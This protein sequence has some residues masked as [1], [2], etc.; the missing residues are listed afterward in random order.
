MEPLLDGEE[1]VQKKDPMKAVEL[2]DIALRNNPDTRKTWADARAAAFGLEIA[3]AP[4]YPVL[5]YNQTLDLTATLQNSSTGNDSVTDIATMN[6]GASVSQTDITSGPNGQFDQLAIGTLSM[7]YLLLDFGGRMSAIESARQALYAANWL[8]NQRIQ[9]VIHDVLTTLNDHLAAKALLVSAQTS[10]KEAQ[11]NLDLA[12][13]Q[14]D[15]GVKTIVDVLQAKSNLVNVQLNVEQISGDVKT[16]LGQLAKAIGLPANTEFRT[17]DLPDE[18][19]LD[20]LTQS[21]QELVDKAKID[22]PD[23][24]SAE[25]FYLQKEADLWTAWS[26]GMPTLS[27]DAE[28]QKNKTIHSSTLNTTFLN[29]A[30]M[31]N[32]PIFSGFLYV[33]QVRQARENIESAYA[34]M[35]SREAQILLDVVTAYYSYKTAL[36]TVRYS[37]EYLKYAQE[38]Y[39]AAFASYQ[40]GVGIFLDVLTAQN[41]LAQARARKIQARTQLLRALANIAYSTGA[42]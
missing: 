9:D 25:A 38:A 34:A 36:E 16:T 2:I 7:T 14:F 15:A 26:A 28:I 33:N 23:L 31:L 19:K 3:K 8:H 6:G 21:L 18:L 32:V 41:T 12:Q 17:Q 10:L 22:R 29:G 42:L 35:Q 24:A 20:D 1:E 11:E 5:T 40:F 37:D 39:E 4:L 27:V 13:G 30:L